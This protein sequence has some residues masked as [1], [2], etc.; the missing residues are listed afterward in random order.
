MLSGG[1]LDNGLLGGKGAAF[2]QEQ[3]KEAL[4]GLAPPDSMTEGSSRLEPR[5]REI[6][7][8]ERRVR[9]C[10]ERVRQHKTL[11]SSGALER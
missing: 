3:A 5:L 4:R 10:I 1:R 11:T 9:P 6:T 8:G 7:N 2:G